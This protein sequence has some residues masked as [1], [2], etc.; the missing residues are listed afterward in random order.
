MLEGGAMALQLASE[1]FSVIGEKSRLKIILFCLEAEKPV[2]ELLVH[3]G[4]EKSLLS[5]HLKV[6][7]EHNILLVRRQGREACYQVNR[8]LLHSSK[9]NTL[10]LACCNIE[11]K[12][13][14]AH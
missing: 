5:K 6:L 12:T 2:H 11:L 8:E 10:N 3:T 7:R 9:S 14:D 13:L 1:L 4:L